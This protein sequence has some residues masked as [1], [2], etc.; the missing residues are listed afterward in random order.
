MAFISGKGMSVL[1]WPPNSPD[2]N[3]IENL[4]GILKNSGSKHR[5]TSKDELIDVARREWALIPQQ[6]IQNCYS[7]MG[8][9]IQQVLERNGRKCDY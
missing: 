6:I 1:E 9:R 7:S 8:T 2:L 4:W 5:I 3:P